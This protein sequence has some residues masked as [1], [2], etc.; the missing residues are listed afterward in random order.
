M[1]LLNLIFYF[2]IIQGF[3]T[4]LGASAL[5]TTPAPRN[6]V[7]S[8]TNYTRAFGGFTQPPFS[9]PA[10]PMSNSC[11]L[12]GLSRRFTVEKRFF[13][14]KTG[15]LH[16]GGTYLLTPCLIWRGYQMVTPKVH[17]YSHENHV[18]TVNTRS[19]KCQDMHVALEMYGSREEITYFAT[20]KPLTLVQ[21]HTLSNLV[22]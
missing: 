13:H 5:S 2:T 15:I 20:N 18:C 10:L 6:E 19:T 7:S 16:P 22:A 17:L 12:V 11:F 1:L 9:W 4:S 3:A 14:F 21:L 8:T